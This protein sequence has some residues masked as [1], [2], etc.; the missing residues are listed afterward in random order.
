MNLRFSLLSLKIRDVLFIAEIRGY[1]C[2]ELYFIDTGHYPSKHEML[3]YV[4][5]MLVHRLRC[6]PNIKPKFGLCRVF[7]G[8]VQCYSHCVQN[9]SKS[10]NIWHVLQK[11]DTNSKH[12]IIEKHISLHV[13]FYYRFS[14]QFISRLLKTEGFQK[15]IMTLIGDHNWILNSFSQF[16]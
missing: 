7:I 10:Q 14:P 5:L 6:Y 12:Q 8:Y 16:R 13:A 15:Y 4:V 11:N 3:T 9:L 1:L 2:V